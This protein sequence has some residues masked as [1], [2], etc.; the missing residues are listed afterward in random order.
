MNERGLV[1]INNPVNVIKGRN[2][3]ITVETVSG[4]VVY[5]GYHKVFIRV[6]KI[7]I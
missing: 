3:T 6:L 5:H 4:V 7:F 1:K 2:E